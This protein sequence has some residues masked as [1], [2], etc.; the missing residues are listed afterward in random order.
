MRAVTTLRLAAVALVILGLTGAEKPS[1][2]P[3]TIQETARTVGIE[4]VLKNHATPNKYQ[5][6]TMPAGVAVFDYNNDSFEDIY[7]A[8]SGCQ[9]YVVVGRRNPV[10]F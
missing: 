3:I 7:W 10:T 2:V 4:F 1:F 6:E 8:C 9:Q 5:V